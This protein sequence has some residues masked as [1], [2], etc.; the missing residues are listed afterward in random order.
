[1]AVSGAVTSS[2][3]YPWTNSSFNLGAFDFAWNNV[4]ASGT[5][6]FDEISV[7]STISNFGPK[8]NDTYHLGAYDNAWSNIY[9]SGTLYGASAEFDWD[10]T[11][12]HDFFSYGD[13]TIGSDISDAITVNGYIDSDVLSA[14]IDLGGYVGFWKDIYASGTLQMG[15]NDNNTTSTFS[16][17]VE[18]SGNIGHIDGA[19]A[20]TTIAG[21]LQVNEDLNVTGDIMMN[22]SDVW[23][24]EYISSESDTT[25]DPNTF[26]FTAPAGAKYALMEHWYHISD[27][28]TTYVKTSNMYI[29]STTG[30]KWLSQEGY[31]DVRLTATWNTTSTPVNVVGTVPVGS[32]Y[33]STNVII[34]WYK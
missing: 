19:G 1:L 32:T 31:N 26:N 14:N 9:T 17:S 27:A 20:T 24:H 18:I 13:T 29:D 23:K 25:G 4:Y 15:S 3:I 22:G 8:E 5:A 16:Q 30:G 33:K 7:T 12:E 34:Y 11:V 2:N 6:Y 10:L 21:N 28:P